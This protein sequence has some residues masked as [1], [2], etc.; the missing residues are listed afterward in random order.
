[1]LSWPRRESKAK[2]H[3]PAIQKRVAYRQIRAATVRERIPWIVGGMHYR[4]HPAGVQQE[5]PGRKP[6]DERHENRTSP[7]RAKQVG[8]N[9]RI[10]SVS[11][12]M[13]AMSRAFS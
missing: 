5:S 3:A 2:R 4:S 13:C 10:T 9:P 6:W 7:E 12:L 11:G 1:M 8:P